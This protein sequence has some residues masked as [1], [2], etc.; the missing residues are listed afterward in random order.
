MIFGPKRI[1]WVDVF[2]RWLLDFW[3]GGPAALSDWYI[4]FAYGLAHPLRVCDRLLRY[5]LAGQ[6][7]LEQEGAVTHDDLRM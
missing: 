6:W 3:S 2:G 7:R 1:H 5:G 4:R